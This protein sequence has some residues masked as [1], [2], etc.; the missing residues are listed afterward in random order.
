MAFIYFG[1]ICQLASVLRCVFSVPRSC[2]ISFLVSV[3][4]CSLIDLRPNSVD[5]SFI[6]FLFDVG[7]CFVSIAVS[8]L[9][10]DNQTTGH[11]N[12]H[13]HTH[14]HTHT[15]PYATTCQS[16]CTYEAIPLARTTQIPAVLNSCHV[17]EPPSNLIV[18]RG[19]AQGGY[20]EAKEAQAWPAGSASLFEV[21]PG[22]DLGPGAVPATPVTV[23]ATPLSSSLHH[24]ASDGVGGDGAVGSS[25]FPTLLDASG[26]DDPP[27][28]G[29]GACHVGSSDDADASGV[30][31]DDA[32]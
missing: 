13:T 23:A 15:Q 20:W 28:T 5:L 1:A 22:T 16:T 21:A 30:A 11:S 12:T 29:G 19:A 24:L 3:S 32:S 14:A 2:R 6:L 10:P 26:S 9:M 7:L 27:E 17:N 25:A 4:S 8:I 18:L 31:P